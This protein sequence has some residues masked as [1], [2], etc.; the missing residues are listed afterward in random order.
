[1]SGPI[2]C[3][4]ALGAAILL[5]T[6]AARATALAQTAPEAPRYA[7][8]IGNNQPPD[9]GGALA[10]LRY[11]D[12]D[13]LRYRELF[14][15]LGGKVTLLTVLDSASQRRYPRAAQNTLPPSAENL[16]RSVAAIRAEIERDLAR[17]ARPALIVTFSGH[18][19]TAANGES[20]LALHGGGALTRERLL[21]WVVRRFADIPLHLIVD[22]CSAGSVLGLRGPFD[23]ELDGSTV[24]LGQAERAWLDAR[25]I[26]DF[27]LTG[28]LVASAPEQQA[29]E[30]SRIESGVFSHEVI[31][32]L[33]G[34]A[35]VNADLRIEYSEVQAFVAAANR[36]LTDPRA[37]PQIIAHA[38]T[39]DVH[40][41]IVSLQ[42]LVG[43]RMLHGTGDIGHFYIE[44][45]DGQRVLEAHLTSGERFSVAIDTA[46]AAYLRTRTHEAL[47]PSGAQGVTVSQLA[48]TPQQL[49]GRGA[50][51]NALQAQLFASP[52]G[53]EYYRGFVDSHNLVG[54]V[55]GTGSQATGT[56]DADAEHGPSV[57]AWSL[58][59]VAGAALIA[60]GVT[61][62]LALDARA[63][64]DATKVPRTAQGY[65]DDYQ[66]YG[67]FSL[68][69]AALAL[70]SGIAAYVLWPR[71]EPSGTDVA[72]SLRGG[73]GLEFS[74]SW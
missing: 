12:D 28:A 64:F 22:A 4:I 21:D 47:I 52:Y 36:D 56:R 48:L 39:G 16:Q 53:R 18:S 8:V 41:E 69:G 71:S 33:R 67:A 57:L 72:L 14:A 10:P 70:G 73:P 31:S 26:V 58:V 37:R 5:G 34:A 61:G 42:R 25:A 44:R 1:M 7:L 40:T 65:E 32:A 54:V 3:A 13:A 63:E 2:R 17:G 35:D 74:A 62:Y 6:L 20:Y 9:D 24:P 49:S 66:R 19:G 68:V 15:A 27:P 23:R 43:A 55:P 45:A 60:A 29:H 51:A 30:W 11:A 46:Q 50:L 59:G 38:P